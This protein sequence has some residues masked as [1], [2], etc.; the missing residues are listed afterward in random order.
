[1]EIRAPTRRLMKP[2]VQAGGDLED[3]EVGARRRF[4]D[5][6]DAPVLDSEV[7]RVLVSQIGCPP[8]RG[9]FRSELCLTV[10]K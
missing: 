3:P 9:N 1:M 4:P 10:A 8:K 2:D 6:D 7:D 5:F